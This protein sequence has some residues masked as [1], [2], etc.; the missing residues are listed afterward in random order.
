MAGA[1]ITVTVDEHALVEIDQLVGDG[2]FTNRSKASE[3]AVQDRMAK[4]RRSRLALE[5]A[6]LDR[7]EEQTLAG[8]AYVGESD[9]PEY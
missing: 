1:K 7:A 8:A 9:W 5:C 6:K 2:V 4:L 3:A